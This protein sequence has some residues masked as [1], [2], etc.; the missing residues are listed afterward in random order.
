MKLVEQSVEYLRQEEGLEG[1]YKQIER[2]ARVCYKSEDRITEDSARKFVEVLK[3]SGHTST[4]EHGTVY[5]T[6][7]TRVIDDWHRGNEPELQELVREEVIKSQYSKVF[8]EGHFIT[9]NMRVIHEIDSGE[10]LL[11]YMAAPMNGLHEKR[12]TV[13]ITTNRAIANELVRHRVF[14][15]SQEST[16]YCNYTKDKFNNEISFITPQDHLME[17]AYKQCED[18]YFALVNKGIK[19]EIARD[20]LPLGLKTEIVMTGFAS[21][22]A[23]FFTLRTGDNVKGKTGRPHPMM[24]ELAKM[25]RD[26]IMREMTE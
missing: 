3:N 21:D 14:S 16:R 7:P 4:L 6:F 10:L 22:W 18:I 8:A 12:H 23:K 25:I 1:V 20:V 5:L 17:Q 13:K 15:F 9:T 2:A 24:Q 19:P 26:A 11:P